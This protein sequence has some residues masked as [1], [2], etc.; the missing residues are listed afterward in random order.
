MDFI[1]SFAQSFF[2]SMHLDSLLKNFDSL[3]PSSALIL[4][5]LAL[6]LL[7]RMAFGGI[8]RFFPILLVSG[9]ALFGL[10]SSTNSKPDVGL[11]MP[12]IASQASLSPTVLLAVLLAAWLLMRVLRLSFVTMSLIA[13]LVYLSGSQAGE[14]YLKS[15]GLNHT[16]LLMVGLVAIF[17]LTQVIKP[18]I[19]GQPFYP[20]WMQTQKAAPQQVQVVYVP[21][22]SQVPLALS[23][24]ETYSKTK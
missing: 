17:F 23:S 8:L 1:P 5:P 11:E 20:Y 19:Y 24:Q 13:G 4:A 15:I 22:P 3:S 14:P 7:R 6:P 18:A 2:S 16:D 21:Y 10:Y 12:A 9:L